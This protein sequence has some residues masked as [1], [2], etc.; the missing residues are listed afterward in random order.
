MFQRVVR[1]VFGEKLYRGRG[2]V[3]IRRWIAS[4]PG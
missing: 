4:L 2:A 3:Y 1:R